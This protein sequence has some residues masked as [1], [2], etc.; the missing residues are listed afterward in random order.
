[1]RSRASLLAFFIICHWLASPVR[2]AAQEQSEYEEISVFLMV[3]RI[4]GI[5]MPAVYYKQHLYLPVA[6]L[7]DFL[8]IRNQSSA[9]LDSVSGFFINPEAP[10]VID[11]VNKR[12][13]YNRKITSLKE[14]DLIRTETGLFLRS[15]FFGE[16]F[17]LTCDFNF[18]SLSV[19]LNTTIELPAIREMRQEFMRNNIS[20]MKGAG[21][22]DTLI[23]RSYPRF[24]FGMADWSAVASQELGGATQTRLNL[25]LGA[26][27]A[28]GE[29][30]IGLNYNV[31]EK[32]QE[33]EQ[34]YIWRLVNN[35]NRALRQLM[36]GKINH[37]AVSSIFVPVVG[38]QITNAPTIYRRSFGTYTLSDK[39]EPGWAVE[40]YV[41]NVLVDHVKAD[42]SGFYTFEVPLMYGNTQVLLRFYGPW[43]EERSVQQNISVPY[44]FLPQKE[45]QYTVSAGM[46]EDS[47]HSIFSRASA[48]YGLAPRVTVGG[49][50]EYLSSVAS[51]K[52]M[53]FVNTSVRLGSGLLFLGDYTY[54]VRARGILNYRTASNFQIELNYTRYDKN[55]MAINYNYL[56]ERKAI[57]TL[58]IRGK[59]FAAFTRLT[60]NQIVLPSTQFTTAEWLMSGI[61]LKVSTNLTTY[62]VIASQVNP[63]VY[64]NL[65]LGFRFPGRFIVR[66][67]LQY[68]YTGRRITLAKAEIEKQFSRSGFLSLSYE[69]NFKTGV[70]SIQGG[71]RYD[72]NFAQSVFQVRRSSDITTFMQ[73]A[74]GSLLFDGKTHY[75]GATNRTSVGRGGIVLIPFLDMNRNGRQDPDERRI[76]GLNIS[77]NGG[78]TEQSQRDTLVRIFDLEPYTNYFVEIDQ[79]SFDN[80][81]WQIN[82]K[83]LSVAVDPNQFK[84]IELPVVVAGEVSGT[85]VINTMGTVKGL[86]RIIV[87]IMRPDSTRAARTLTESDGYFSYL[88]LAPGDYIAQIDGGQLKKLYLSNTPDGIPF[89]IQK[90]IDGDVA[91]GLEFILRSNRQDTTVLNKPEAV[92]KKD[93]IPSEPKRDTVQQVILKD[94]LPIEV[95]KEPEVKVQDLAKDPVYA[96]QIAAS[97]TFVMPADFKEKFSL[98][99]EVY[100]FLKDGWYKYVVGRFKTSS[101]AEAYRLSSKIAGFVTQVPKRD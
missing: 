29:T 58:P 42:A 32:F 28:G 5:E 52:F 60:L 8:K 33:R 101:E 23:G 43:G 53:P 45:F 80:I 96:I 79:N 87:D 95:K 34:H 54:G 22:A 69:M 77:I 31:G 30:N 12:I 59:N 48:N 49:G 47:L 51:G 10:Y 94:T 19:N 84:R 91:D 27:V 65:T 36:V 74:R 38:A 37:Q 11:Q 90:S 73:T 50:M 64:S 92:S 72:F 57:I 78:R 25:A 68:E 82:L 66:P 7:F 21:E 6:E 85:V 13:D 63:Y 62:A 40:L 100:W 93:S 70:Q 56:E 26:V 35:D 61:I 98:T 55:Q 44:N 2:V 20:K 17:G 71:F 39:T 76:P 67:Q 16:V 15:E 18:R 9:S 75:A 24:R 14:E 88:G 81:A 4:G 1:M 89:T 97:K 99:D 41:N 83:N 3:Q 46:V 86:G